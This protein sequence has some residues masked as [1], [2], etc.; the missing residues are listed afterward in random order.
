MTIAELLADLAHTPQLPGAACRGRWE[1][2]DTAATRGSGPVTMHQARSQALEI[3]MG[4][5]ALDACR[6]WLNHLPPEQR[7]RGVTAG[8]VIASR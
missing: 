6:H 3:C 7:P 8:I 5:P 2:F 4:C 1:L